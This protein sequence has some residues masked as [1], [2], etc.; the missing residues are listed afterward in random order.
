MSAVVAG[1]NVT[2]TAALLMA[3]LASG[4][5]EVDRGRLQR[6]LGRVMTLLAHTGQVDPATVSDL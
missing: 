1:D 4:A 3:F 5:V 6:E 2:A